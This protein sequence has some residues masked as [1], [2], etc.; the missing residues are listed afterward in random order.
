MENKEE[1]N[2]VERQRSDTFPG[3]EGEYRLTV[4][5]FRACWKAFEKSKGTLKTYEI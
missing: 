1:K 4:K 5:C 2:K 3:K